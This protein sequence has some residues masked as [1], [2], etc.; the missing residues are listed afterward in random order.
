MSD[1][2]I[3]IIADGKDE[4]QSKTEPS[5]RKKERNGKLKDKEE[6][7]ENSVANNEK[8]QDLLRNSQ[9][10][11]SK[12]DSDLASIETAEMHALSRRVYVE[13]PD[14]DPAKG[15]TR[16][17]CPCC[18][19]PV[20]GTQLNLCCQPEELSELGS[21]FPMIFKLNRYSIVALVLVSLV[22]SIP[23][24][25]DNI[26]QGKDEW[27]YENSFNL[28]TPAT[29]GKNFEVSVWQPILHIAVCGALVFFF[30]WVIGKIKAQSIEIDTLLTTPS[31]FTLVV[32]GLPHDYKP[33]DLRSHIEKHFQMRNMKIANLVPTYDISEYMQTTL[34]LNDWKFQYKLVKNY[35]KKYNKPMVATKCFCCKTELEGPEGCKAEIEELKKKLKEMISNMNTEKM[36]SVAFVTM[37]NQITTREIA[38]EMGRSNVQRIFDRIFP[39]FL[40]ERHKFNGKYIHAEMAPDHS[41]VNWENLA[42]P[43]SKKLFR[44]LITVFVALLVLGVAVAIMAGTAAWKVQVKENKENESA[45]SIRAATIIP[46]II[47]VMINFIVARII[48]VLSAYEKHS[49]WTDFNRSVLNML[50]VFILLNNIGIPIFIYIALD[51]DWFSF[52]GLAYTVFW[53]EIMNAFVSP[54]IYLVGPKNMAKKLMQFIYRRKENNEELNISQKQANLVF[55]GP[56]LDLPDRF[57]NI[58]KNF[59]LSLFYAPIVPIGVPIAIIGLV[60]EMM[61]FKV[62]LVRV[63]SRPKNYNSDLVIQAAS[64]IR[65]GLLLYSLGIFIFYQ[66]LVEELFYLEL[67]FFIAMCGYT[68]TPISALCDCCF[69]DKTLEILRK[70]YENDQKYNNYFSVLPKFYSDYERENPVTRE[71]GMKRFDIFLDCL[72][73]ESYFEMKHIKKQDLPP[74]NQE[75]KSSNSISDQENEMN[76]AEVNNLVPQVGYQTSIPIA[77]N[78]GYYP[79]IPSYVTSVPQSSYPADYGTNISYP[80]LPPPPSPYQPYPN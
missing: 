51:Q 58:I 52:G 55:E 76:A 50:I 28:L 16:Q 17:R 32:R 67:F 72:T 70:E 30:M 54:V 75:N 27:T 34:L 44:R 10:R 29:F 39:C 71:K 40:N 61:A 63:H 79:Y 56:E 42:V 41:D 9:V 45:D 64:W 6:N 47:T 8:S 59:S 15:I 43:T 46:S 73:P 31:D 18:G 36:G 53:L 37:T 4:K 19:F 2:E 60:F 5:K 3:D 48:R 7:Q 1:R 24:F 65:W 14:N 57:A 22:A 35:H 11:D 38:E 66:K 33:D 21:S 23:C 62:M 69:K 80:N 20:T 74:D 78:E 12:H 68:L 25:A 77:P 13:T 49:T 26:S